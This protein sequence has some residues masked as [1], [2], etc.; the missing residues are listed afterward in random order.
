MVCWVKRLWKKFNEEVLLK[1][2]IAV[3]IAVVVAVAGS[4]FMLN[5][6]LQLLSLYVAINIIL[7]TSLNLINGVTGQFSLG[8]AGFMA[9]G[10]YVSAVCSLHIPGIPLFLCPIFG[11][12]AAA[13]CGFAV[14]APSLRLRGDYLAIVTLG[15][16]EIIRVVVLNLEITGGARGL[17][18]I[19]GLF[20]FW[21]SSV[22]CWTY[23]AVILLLSWRLYHSSWGRAFQ[24]IR[25]D[26]LAAQIM[27]VPVVKRKIAAF[28]ISSFFAGIGGGLLA[29]V[30]NYLNP[31][32]FGFVRSVEIII[33]IVLGGLGSW[34]GAIIG[35]TIVTLLPEFLRPLQEWTGIDL[36]M[37]IYSMMLL[38]VVI[39]RP[40]GLVGQVEWTSWRKRKKTA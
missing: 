2:W 28:V 29:H 32:N 22:V 16:G 6:Y 19:P 30:T 36:R 33:M 9:V 38:L 40:Q 39:L 3:L 37:V 5:D 25:E 21:N 11:G 8:H 20:P 26:E 31:A 34:T 23:C 7:A 12:L 24:S 4:T 1:G 13:A 27:A 15:F 18:G 17:E 35:A 10:A 14:G